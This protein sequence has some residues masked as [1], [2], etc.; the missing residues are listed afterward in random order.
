ML[1]P[2]PGQNLPPKSYSSL[3]VFQCA[4]GNV[5]SLPWRSFKQGRKTCGACVVYELK[6]S[7]NKVFG[8]LTLIQ[9]LDISAGVGQLASWRCGC[10]VFKKIHLNQVLRG[11]RSCGCDKPGKARHAEKEAYLWKKEI[12]NLILDQNTPQ[13]WSQ[14]SDRL[15]S[16]MCDCGKIFSK[17]FCHFKPGRS[18][19]GHCHTIKISNGDVAKEFIYRGSKETLST[20]STLTDL[21]ECK[22]GN[23]KPIR[24]YSVFQTNQKTCGDCNKHNA[25]WWAKAK[26]GRLRA[27]FPETM[28]GKSTGSNDLAEF[29]CD[30]G[31][32]FVRKI[33]KST[34]KNSS[35]GSCKVVSGK[36]YAEHSQ[37]LKS[38]TFPMKASDFPSGGPKPLNDI[39]HPSKKTLFKCWLCGRNYET[40]PLDVMRGYSLSC[41]CA[42]GKISKPNVELHSWLSALGANPT[43]EHSVGNFRYDV[44]ISEK[45]VAI[46]IQ[47]LRW[48]SMD[49]AVRRD[50]KKFD[51]L[52]KHG[53]EG[54]FI[55]EDEWSQK[56]DV[57]KS[58]IMNRLKMSKQS[59]VLRPS[60]CEFR[61]ID[62]KQANDFYNKYHYIGACDNAYNFGAFHGERLLACSS[63]RRPSRQTIC[64]EF[65]V[66]RMASVFDVRIYG[67]WS[68]FFQLFRKQKNPKS[69]VTY[70]DDRLFTGTVYERMGFKKDG[71]VKPDYYWVFNNKR[72]HK[73]VLRKP[74]NCDVSERVLRTEQGYRQIWDF[75]KT[76]WVFKQ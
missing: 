53:W 41:G 58:M 31:A 38:L 68:V 40:V 17:R 16:F 69:L 72:L 66:S 46:E 48:H 70:S 24:I 25:E 35:C 21:F 23:I 8:K 32:E 33:C 50:K 64:Q 74:Q 20:R 7:G 47:G 9:D 29:V 71:K 42:S 63:F 76:R 3:V 11:T 60:K 30:C 14:G 28:S 65:E 6:N 52:L 49:G 15:F 75:G 19:C 18:K 34:L 27:K 12:P 10:G 61:E 44:G 5:V 39:V 73:S 37:D 45:R 22:C 56:Q 13:A 43:L 2:V 67:V 54:L 36:W 51:N 4:C 59:A 55:F 1:T 26:F 62:A 57:I